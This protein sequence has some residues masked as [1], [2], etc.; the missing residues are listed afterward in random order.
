MKIRADFVL[1]FGYLDMIDDARK[2][3]S[4]H[5]LTSDDVALRK[6]NDTVYIITKREI[7]LCKNPMS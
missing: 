6:R 5:N 3:I 2:Y 1:Y 4:D 7:E